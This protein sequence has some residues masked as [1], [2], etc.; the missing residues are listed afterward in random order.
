[1]EG[2]RNKDKSRVGF[3]ME[4]LYHCGSSEK[5]AASYRQERKGREGGR[6][7]DGGTFASHGVVRLEGEIGL[8]RH[9]GEA[10]VACVARDRVHG[11]PN[12]RV[13]RVVHTRIL[14]L[15]RDLC[16]KLAIER[17]LLPVT[18][19]IEQIRR[20]RCPSCRTDRIGDC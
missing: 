14:L 4:H 6:A 11:P 3:V 10:L 17:T 5:E 1:M 16:V 7:E 15:D 2:A 8:G 19:V 20:L 12:C 18:A 9:F 13:L